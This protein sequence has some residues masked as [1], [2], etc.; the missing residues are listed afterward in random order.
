M[1]LTFVT[2][3]PPSIIHIV[4]CFKAAIQYDS[5]QSQRMSISIKIVKCKTELG[6]C[7]VRFV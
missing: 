5:T 4:P 1:D 7:V 3:V 2:P 6:N